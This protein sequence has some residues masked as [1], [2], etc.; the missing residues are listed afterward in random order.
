MNGFILDLQGPM[1]SFADRG[2][3]Q[4]REE[5]EFPSRSAVIG[6][7]AAAMGVERGSE[8]LL[9]LHAGLRIHTARVRSGALLVDYHTVLTAGYDEYDPARLRREGA[10]GN[11]TLTWRSYHCDG[12]F[13]ALVEGNDG[14]LI[15]ECRQALRSPVYTSFLGRRSCPPSTPLLPHE[16][17][18]GT[19]VQALLNAVRRGDYV[20]KK[21]RKH[22][23]DRP[24]TEFTAWLDGS[25]RQGHPATACDGGEPQITAEGFRRDLLTALPRS[26][27]NRPVTHV[28][29]A[30]PA[31]PP[32]SNQEFYH[33]AP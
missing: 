19:Q 12:H 28:R 7:V 21:S 2:F 23:R 25:F 26:Y 10:E 22:Y 27:V 17:D 11:P 6:I 32:I 5:G 31:P 14:E 29:V 8:R 16:V 33:A 13:V 1:M 4:L 30:L 24:L 9:E 15:E 3:G 18:G 20:R